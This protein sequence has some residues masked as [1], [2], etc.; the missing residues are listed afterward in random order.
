M[1]PPESPRSHHGKVNEGIRGKAK[2]CGKPLGLEER[3]GVR[4]LEKE[5]EN[6]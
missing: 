1:E 3:R 2:S 5:P 6:N 4:I